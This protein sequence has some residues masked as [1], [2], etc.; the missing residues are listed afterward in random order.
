MSY[1][2][3]VNVHASSGLL[4]ASGRNGDVRTGLRDKRPVPTYGQ[5]P[6]LTPF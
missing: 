4:S 2:A 6:R 1:G 3:R 5:F